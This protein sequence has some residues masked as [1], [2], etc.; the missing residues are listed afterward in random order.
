MFEVKK[1]SSERWK[2][3]RDLR[4]EALKS[5]PI[6]FSSSYE[7]EKN[8]TED[9]WKKRINNALLAFSNDKLVGIIVYIINNKNK[10]KHIAN[11]FGVYVKKEYRRQGIGKKMIENALKII[12]KN[13]IVSK[14][15]LG[16]NPELKAAVKLYEKCG[17]NIV[18]RLK[19]ELKVDGKFYDE[20]IMEKFI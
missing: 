18:G 4:L 3:Y 2:E 14:I 11:I 13:V 6:A 19:N 16:V 15:K 20:L 1:L 5:D 7:E 8:I 9:E 10:T 17:F 12:Q